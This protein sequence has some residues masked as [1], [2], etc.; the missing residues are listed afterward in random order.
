MVRMLNKYKLSK[1]KAGLLRYFVDGKKGFYH[2]HS[3][4]M[5]TTQRKVY[6][7]LKTKG[8]I[9]KKKPAKRVK[10]GNM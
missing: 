6:K 2:I 9:K 10:W 4:E 7:R 5:T 8:G 3:G 1:D